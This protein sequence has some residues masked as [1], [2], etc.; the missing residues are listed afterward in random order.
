MRQDDTWHAAGAFEDSTVTIS[1]TQNDWEQVTNA[2]NNLLQA[3]VANGFAASG[4]T[5]EFLNA[6]DYE[7]WLNFTFTGFT[8]QV[9]KFRVW[10]VT[11][12]V[13]EWVGK[14]QTG[15]GAGDFVGIFITTYFNDV[16]AGD[17]FIIQ[18][19]NTD[20]SNDITIREASFFV[21][22]LHD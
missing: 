6:G 14:S 8:S 7:G 1:I 3:T 21:N 12:G 17:K 11:D 4:D 16:S 15:D 18:V 2:T 9:Y 13:V 20:G 10:N 19:T 5:L 22:Y